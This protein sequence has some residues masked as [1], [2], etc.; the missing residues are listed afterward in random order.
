[1]ILSSFGLRNIPD[2]KVFPFSL[3]LIENLESISLKKPVTFFVGENGSGKSTILESLAYAANVPTVGG[4]SIE[5]DPLM[6]PARSLGKMLSLRFQEKTS[7]GFFVRA[8]DF[9]GFVKNI[10]RNIAELDAEM[11]E[12]KENWTGGDLD[13]ALATLK[14]ERIGY[15]D[16][17]TEN[18]DG[19]SH[20]EGFL[21]FFNN[22]ITGKGL[23]L[24]DEP[25]AALSPARQ[26]SLIKIIMDAVNTKGSQFI[27]ATH[28]PIIMAMPDA[29]VLHFDEG[30]I[31][32]THYTETNH[33]QLTK[34][35]IESPERFTT[36]L[37]K[38]A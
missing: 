20:G 25:E 35:F 28:S 11:Q 38:K 19:M 27:I 31:T 22:R 23:Y 2:E 17:Y 9:L 32:E 16:R 36:A 26:L 15:T 10:L 1:M 5:E 30:I 14:S 33:F 4:M 34:A 8:E 13:R 3:P 29:Q 21:R 24:I 37:Q 18:F 6:E 7:A 12:I